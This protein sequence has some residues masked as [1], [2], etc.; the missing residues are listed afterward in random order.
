MDLQNIRRSQANPALVGGLVEGFVRAELRGDARVAAILFERLC[1]WTDGKNIRVVVQALVAHSLLG[2]QEKDKTVSLL[3]D[4]LEPRSGKIRQIVEAL[5]AEGIQTRPML[6]AVG[7]ELGTISIEYP[8]QV[9]ETVNKL[10]DLA[11]KEESKE[12]ARLVLESFSTRCPKEARDLLSKFINDF[13]DHSVEEVTTAI[14]FLPLPLQEDAE[15]AESTLD[16]LLAILHERHSFEVKRSVLKTLGA[17]CKALP[18]RARDITDAIVE[19]STRHHEVEIRKIALAQLPEA[20]RA[21]WQ[22]SKEIISVIFKVAESQPEVEEEALR[23]VPA[24][25]AA[26]PSSSDVFIDWMLSIAARPHM[27]EG[28]LDAVMAALTGSVGLNQCRGRVEELYS[29]ILS[30]L[31]RGVPRSARLVALKVVGEAIFKCPQEAG[32]VLDALFRA[33]RESDADITIAALPQ[34]LPA[35]VAFPKKQ[36][37]ALAMVMECCTDGNVEVRCAAVREFVRVANV[38]PRVFLKMVHGLV[39]GE[40]EC[41]KKEIRSTARSLLLTI[42]R[43]DM[44]TG[45][46]IVASLIRRPRRVSQSDRGRK[47]TLGE[48]AEVEDTPS[49]NRK[50]H[51]GSPSEGR[52]RGR[53]RNHGEDADEDDG[54]SSSRK[55]R[56]R[57]PSE[58]RTAHDG[59]QQ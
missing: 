22:R 51:R 27:S 47:R 52:G 15:E 33:V 44:L 35:S 9:A 2:G 53:K 54:S 43:G 8:T 39:M 42:T 49:P 38:F 20:L 36:G 7:G 25:I 56:R 50:K 31:R 5:V 55:E 1:M 12:A 17:W 34:L 18:Q 30:N 37:E 45:A 23:Q 29:V 59:H 4:L 6:I 57:S 32:L 14:E 24:Y 13:R 3:L 40:K 28:T 10:L 48:D 21:C 58:D 26:R 16:S 11:S 41:D 19:R 46:D